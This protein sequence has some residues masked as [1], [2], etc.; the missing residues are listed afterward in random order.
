MEREELPGKLCHKNQG[1]HLFL[2]V[3][4]TFGPFSS[5]NL[6]SFTGPNIKLTMDER[7]VNAG[8]GKCVVWSLSRLKHELQM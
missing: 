6:G 2:C 1:F 7:K 3:Y 4:V 8:G 5:F